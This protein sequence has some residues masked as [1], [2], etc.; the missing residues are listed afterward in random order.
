MA[1]YYP[2]RSATVE[3]VL[4][5]FKRFD[6]EGFNEDE[7]DR[8]ENVAFAKLRGKGAPKKKRTAAGMIDIS[9]DDECETDHSYRESGEQEEKV[10]QIGTAL[11][12]CILSQRYPGQNWR[13]NCC[14]IRL[15]FLDQRPDHLFLPLCSGGVTRTP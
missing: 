14:T 1:A 15:M 9:A 4:N 7:D 6:L 10:I 8:L 2:R 3:D 12:C 11:N 13:K 5:E